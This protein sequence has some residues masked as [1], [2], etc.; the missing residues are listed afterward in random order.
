MMP[1]RVALVTI[2]ATSSDRQDQHT[3]S[4]YIPFDRIVSPYS[5]FTYSTPPRFIHSHLIQALPESLE[6]ES[7]ALELSS[8]PPLSIAES[9]AVSREDV[10]EVRE[11]V[12][13]AITLW[14]AEASAGAVFWGRMEFSAILRRFAVA[15]RLLLRGYMILERR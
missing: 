7:E 5:S 12:S 14:L 9:E 2:S 13:S 15:F 11:A 10:S 4:G 8:S 1:Q 3:Y 6:I